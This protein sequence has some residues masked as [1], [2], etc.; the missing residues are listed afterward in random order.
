MEEGGSGGNV[1]LQLRNPVE[2]AGPSSSVKGRLAYVP[3]KGN[4][5]PSVSFFSGAPSKSKKFGY[6]LN[7]TPV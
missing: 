2:I 1:N 3:E 7:V 6:M 5:S 4:L